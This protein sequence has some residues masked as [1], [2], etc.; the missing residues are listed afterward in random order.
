M[1]T[2]LQM[3]S[4]RAR[5]GGSCLRARLRGDESGFLLIEVMMSALL[6][7]LIVTATFNGFDVASRVTID[8]RRHSEAE[9]LA[10]ESQEQLRSDPATALDVLETSP[11]SYTREVTNNSTST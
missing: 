1:R 5:R 9:L 7:A 8:Q 11:H 4:A 10:S 2:F 6:V 3:T